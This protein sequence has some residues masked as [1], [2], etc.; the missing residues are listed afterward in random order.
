MPNMNAASHTMSINLALGYMMAATC[1]E[2]LSAAATASTLRPHARMQILVSCCV[3]Q[4]GHGT[5]GIL[6][7]VESHSEGGVLHGEDECGEGGVPRGED[8]GSNTKGT[9]HRLGT[10]GE[11]TWASE[12][13][14]LHMQQIW[15]K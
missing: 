2:H 5:G 1:G 3:S 13:L 7:E 15:L 10:K 4:A 12:Q 14:A 11:P 8:S 9:W 6:E